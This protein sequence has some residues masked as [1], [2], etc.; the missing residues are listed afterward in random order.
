MVWDYFDRIICI[1]LLDR[2]D[3]YD[4]MKKITNRLKI[5]IEFYRITRDPKSGEKG[6]YESHLKVIKNAYDDNL[7]NVLIFEDDILETTDYDLKHI[8]KATEFMKSNNNWDLMMLGY[9][10][11]LFTIPHKINQNI[12]KHRCWGGFAYAVSR[13][14]MEKIIQHPNYTGKGVDEY[15][16]RFEQYLYY[17]LQFV[18]SLENQSDVPK[19]GG[20]NLPFNRIWPN[21]VIFVNDITAKYI[22]H[23][24]FS[25]IIILVF[26]L[27]LNEVRKKILK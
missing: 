22:Y 24:P 19:L 3:K 12:L 26:L 13:K 4:Y 7:Q 15:F 14:G 23:F 8:K 17:P 10:V 1:N 2:P 16:Q 21:R 25:L 9:G 6:C 27:I 5:P 11:N 18:T 20:I